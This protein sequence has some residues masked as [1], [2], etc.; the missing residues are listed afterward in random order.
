MSV[1]VAELNDASM[2][3]PE[4][5]DGMTEDCLVCQ[6]HRLDVPPPG[7]HLVSSD[8]VVAFHVPPWPPPTHDVYLGYLMVTSRRH[9][10]R[11]PGN[12][13]SVSWLHVD[14]W[15]GARRG[16]F[17]TAARFAVQLKEAMES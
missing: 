3:E 2:S 10:P 13:D 9:V 17:D 6:E 1:R 14:D 12:P 11:W 4:K 15:D 5:G 7:G 16:D 8:E